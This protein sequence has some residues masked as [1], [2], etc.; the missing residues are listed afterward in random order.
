MVSENEGE[1]RSMFLCAFATPPSASAVPSADIKQYQG[2]LLT[3]V[4]GASGTLPQAN[5]PSAPSLAGN[6]TRGTTTMGS[7]KYQTTE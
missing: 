7:S 3:L 6:D 2:L 1:D 4:F 5:L